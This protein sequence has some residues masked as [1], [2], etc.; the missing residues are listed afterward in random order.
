MDENILFLFEGNTQITNEYERNVAASINELGECLNLYQIENVF[1]LDQSIQKTHNAKGYIDMSI[2][3]LERKQAFSINELKGEKEDF[4]FKKLSLEISF[5]NKNDHMKAGMTVEQYKKRKEL[6]IL[7]NIKEQ[8]DVIKELEDRLEII[9]IELKRLERIRE[10][11]SELY[12]SYKKK[13]DYYT[14]QNV[15]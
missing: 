12:M 15:I 1:Q 7:K 11:I 14:R 5:D 9:R 6:T 4:K 13:Y 10:S 2:T 8:Q 3:L